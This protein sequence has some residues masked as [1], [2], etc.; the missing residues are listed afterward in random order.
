MLTNLGPMSLDKI[1]NMLSMFM[2]QGPSG[3]GGAGQTSC[4][5]SELK[6]CLDRKVKGQELICTA[7]TYQLCKNN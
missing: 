2:L 5:I 7:G 3:G 4:T 6:A 1:H